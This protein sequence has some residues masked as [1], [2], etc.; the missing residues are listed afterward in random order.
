MF[1]GELEPI[2]LPP[3]P[4]ATATDS[5][6]LALQQRHTTREVSD[7][8]LDA[9]T[10]SDILW[11]ADGVN[12]KVGPFGALGRTAASASNSQEIDIY[13]A[14]EQGAYK[15]D[16]AKHALLP[17]CAEDVREYCLSAGQRHSRAHGAGSLGSKAPVR[18]I[19]VAD[20]NKLEHTQGFKEPRLKEIEGQKSYYFVDTGLIAGNVYLYAASRGLT[21]WFHNCDKDELIPRL[22]LR[23]D[24]RVL[25]A[26]TIG[27]PIKG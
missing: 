15:Y 5:L 25:F 1:V 3:P 23:D 16:P 13:V 21:A 8:K 19:F 14:L 24:Q 7:A 20:I 18:F 11:A 26:Q 10:L 6:A 2:S 27:H 17:V 22:K 12:R 9:Q 4:V